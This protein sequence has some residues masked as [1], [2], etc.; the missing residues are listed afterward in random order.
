[1]RGSIQFVATRE[2]APSLLPLLRSH[3]QGL[4][5]TALLEQPD[6]EFSAADLAKRLDISYPSIHRELARA[7]QTGIAKSR[8]IGNV[9]LFSA[10][11]ESPYF[12]GLAEVLIRAFGPPEVL[13][14]E[15]SAIDGVEGAAIFGSWAAR[16][17]GVDGPRPV[18]D[19]D[20]LVLGAP[21]RQAVEDAASRAS[22]LLGRR[23]DVTFRG[24][25]WLERGSGPFH[26]TLLSRPW[27]RILPRAQEPAQSE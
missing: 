21:D 7:E 18:N 13:A 3:Q 22:R 20:V 12:H 17:T 16:F 15:L 23:V 11:R 1:M 9:R 5:L 8:R 27:M 6:L 26:A 19:I 4:I 10:N 14:R 2:A 24:A 25:D